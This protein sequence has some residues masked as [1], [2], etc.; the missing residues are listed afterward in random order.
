MGWVHDLSI[1][2]PLY[3]LPVAMAIAMFAQQ[4]LTPTTSADPTQ[5]KIMMFM[6][7][8]FGFIMKD[9]PSGL[10]LY[11]FV[12]TLFGILQQLLVY[13]VTD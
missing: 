11:I 8:I 2:D 6:P 13:K 7:L 5:Q 9:L 12:S 4:K 1:K 10:V 3:I